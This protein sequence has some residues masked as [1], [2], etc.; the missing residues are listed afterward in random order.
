MLFWICWIHGFHL[1][2]PTTSR[3]LT[4]HQHRRMLILTS[5]MILYWW[6]IFWVGILWMLYFVPHQSIKFRYSSRY[7]PHHSLSTLLSQL[8]LSVFQSL[9]PTATQST[10]TPSLRRR[11]LGSPWPL[12]FWPGGSGSR[13]TSSDTRTVD[14]RLFRLLWG[15]FGRWLEVLNGRTG[16]CW[17]AI[18]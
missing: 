17:V 1:H 18:P 10:M 4:H 3:C 11:E 9:C 16:S 13:L 6:F 14:P 5:A 2:G 8:M 7:H 15:R 12:G